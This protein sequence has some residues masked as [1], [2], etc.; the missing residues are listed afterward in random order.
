LPPKILVIG[1]KDHD[2]ADCVD[3]L[4]PFPNIEDYNSIIINLQTLT[5]DIYNKISHKVSNMKRAIVTVFE[6]QR[7]IFCIMNNPMRPITQEILRNKQTGKLVPYIVSS[8][9]NYDWLPINIEV[10]NRLKGTSIDL[11]NPRFEKYFQWVDSWNLEISMYYGREAAEIIVSTFY[12]IEPIAINLSKKIIAGSLKKINPFTS[13]V[14]QGYEKS[15]IH[16]LPP[17]TKCDTHKVIEILLDLIH[18]KITKRVPPWRMDIDVPK[19]KEL[20]RKIDDKVKDINKIRKEIF[21]IGNQIQEWDS[22]RDLLTETGDNLENVVQKT[23]TDMGIKTERTERGFP[24]DLLSNEVAVEI[25]GIKSCVGVGSE[26][27]NQTGRFKESYH[28]SEKI[29]L[30]ANTYMD[31]PP[32]DRKGKID[33]SPEVKKYFDSLSVCYLTTMTLF[34]LWKEVATG[35]KDPNEVKSK[36]LIKNGELTLSDLT[37]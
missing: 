18:G 22:Y 19:I 5:Q 20:E 13:K 34:Q 26:K 21:S 10:N 30:I 15:A 9:T 1:S 7:E 23:L 32:K 16:L 4:Q 8:N 36:I 24:A 31:L 11:C 35:R 27:V 28:K 3:W 25:T 14:P 17:P 29:I 37:S 2:R 12:E 33:F 6:T